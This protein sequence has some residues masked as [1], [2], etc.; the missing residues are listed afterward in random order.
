MGAELPAGTGEALQV[1]AEDSSPWVT[2]GQDAS[3]SGNKHKTLILPKVRRSE[4][5][6]FIKAVNFSS[7][8]RAGFPF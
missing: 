4:A 1:P 8:N 7:K 6:G 2:A 5:D 3:N